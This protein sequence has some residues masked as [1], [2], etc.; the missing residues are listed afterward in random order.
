MHHVIQYGNWFDEGLEYGPN[1]MGDYKQ[2]LQ[3]PEVVYAD[4][5]APVVSF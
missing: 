1:D 2:I 5:H 3:K 4:T